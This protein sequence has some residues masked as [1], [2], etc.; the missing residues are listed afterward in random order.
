MSILPDV[1]SKKVDMEAGPQPLDG[2]L[3][4]CGLTNHDLVNAAAPGMLTHK[5]EAKGRR[6]RKLTLRAQ[7][8]IVQ[9]LNLAA[10][11]EVPYRRE[12]CFSYRGR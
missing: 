6:G 4:Q 7:D 3:R 2:L 8:K 12:E 1:R 10:R 11:R 9:A 5:M